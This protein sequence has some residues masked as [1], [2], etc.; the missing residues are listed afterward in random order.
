MLSSA[1]NVTAEFSSRSLQR[2]HLAGARRGLQ[3]CSEGQQTAIAILH[4]KL[5]G[6]PWRVANLA[7]ELD[8]LGGVLGVE[9]VRIFDRQVCIEQFVRV[10]VRIGSGRLGATEMNRVL[11]AR[12]DSV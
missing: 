2:R 4:D 12:N 11:V 8:A 1:G 9:H 10:F 6:L 5:S 7:S 3:I